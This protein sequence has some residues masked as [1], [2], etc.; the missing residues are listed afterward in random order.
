VARADPVT[1]NRILNT[2]DISD[3]SKS[4][5]RDGIKRLYFKKSEHV[6]IDENMLEIQKGRASLTRKTAHT[7][8]RDALVVAIFFVPAFSLRCAARP[9]TELHRLAVSA[10][11]NVRPMCA[12]R[13]CPIMAVMLAVMLA[14]CDSGRHWP[15]VTF[16]GDRAER[17]EASVIGI[18]CLN[19]L[20]VLD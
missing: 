18:G 17:R 2:S 6:L 20:T 11:V 7:F 14:R 12:S 3:V 15:E 13:M 5:P 8:A 16:M 19:L 9:H 4:D 10:P 1:C